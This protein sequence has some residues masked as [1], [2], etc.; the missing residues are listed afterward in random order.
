MSNKVIKNTKEIEKFR[1]LFEKVNDITCKYEKSD[2]KYYVSR[3][4]LLKALEIS[5]LSS[6]YF[7]PTTVFVNNDPTYTLDD[8][9]NFVKYS[10]E[11]YDLRD[12]KKSPIVMWRNSHYVIDYHIPMGWNFTYS[13]QV[14]VITEIVQQCIDKFELRKTKKCIGVNEF[15]MKNSYGLNFRID[16][17]IKLGPF[18]VAIEV[19][20]KTTH[21]KKSML[22]TD[23][24]KELLANL[25]I[26]SVK[27]DEETWNITKDIQ[28]RKINEHLESLLGFTYNVMKKSDELKNLENAMSD[29][30]FESCLNGSDFPFDLNEC[31]KMF[32]VKDN[33]EKHKF[34]M[35]LFESSNVNNNSDSSDSDSENDSHGS[36]STYNSDNSSDST[37]DSDN[38]SADDS[39]DI[40]LSDDVSEKS[41]LTENNSDPYMKDVDFVVLNGKI[42]IEKFTMFQLGQLVGNN[43]S[44]EFMRLV[45]DLL[46]FVEKHSKEAYTKLVNKITNFDVE[47]QFKTF[48]EIHETKSERDV[49]IQKDCVKILKEELDMMK[50]K[51]CK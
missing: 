36:N 40:S 14:N 27:I 5:T 43:R 26:M 50:S 23:M 32:N 51:F 21:T 29:S 37:I 28:I 4:N 30:M 41:D 1:I 44:K 46:N 12:L 17:F 18:S 47:L 11:D 20:E 22:T 25:G 16:Y 15:D 8:V 48:A 45:K 31:L 13:F 34:I 24:K 49:K 42:Y 10:I 19:N 9:M 35:S 38:S 2:D 6:K 39:D 33:S 7:S 3:P